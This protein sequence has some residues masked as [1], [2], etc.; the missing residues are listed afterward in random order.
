[1]TKDTVVAF[2]ATEGFWPDPQTD[3]LRQ[4]AWDLIAQAVEAIFDTRCACA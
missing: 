1:M 2:R 3:L 4:G